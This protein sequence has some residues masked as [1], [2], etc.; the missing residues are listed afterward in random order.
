MEHVL[1][2]IGHINQCTGHILFQVLTAQN[3]IAKVRRP[4]NKHFGFNKNVYMYIIDLLL[5]AIAAPYG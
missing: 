3:R 4:G 2:Q 1:Y 5:D